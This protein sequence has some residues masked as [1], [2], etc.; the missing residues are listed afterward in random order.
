MSPWSRP[1]DLEEVLHKE[2]GPLERK[3]IPDCR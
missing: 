2:A 3:L 1:N